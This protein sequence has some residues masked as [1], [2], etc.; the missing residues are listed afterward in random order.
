MRTAEL[1]QALTTSLMPPL[2]QA[3]VSKVGP[4]HFDLL[5]VIGQGGY[6]KVFQVKKSSGHDKGRIYAMKVLKKVC[7]W[8]LHSLRWEV[9][10]ARCFLFVQIY[11][12]P[13]IGYKR[14]FRKRTSRSFQKQ[15]KTMD[16][17]K[18]K[19]IDGVE[20]KNEREKKERESFVHVCLG[21][22]QRENKE[23]KDRES[24]INISKEEE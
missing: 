9:G 20:R 11:A 15:Y 4:E 13:S 21:H 16:K 5:R 22:S 3:S 8:A 1:E 2:A 6:G 14:T 17:Q 19:E 24:W 12:C 10:R 23:G 18:E 7:F